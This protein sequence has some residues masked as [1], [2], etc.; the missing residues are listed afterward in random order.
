[1]TNSPLYKAGTTIKP[2]GAFIHSVGCPQP[3]ASAFIKTMN[4]AT[5]TK[6]VTA[7]IQPDGTVYETLPINFSKKT[8]IKNWHAGK[9]SKG[10]ANTSW[11]GIELTEPSTI[12]YTSGASFKDLDPEKTKE[13]VANT[14]KYAVEYF[15]YLCEGFGWDPL[16]DGVILSHHEGYVRGYASNHGDVEHIWSKYGYTMDQFRK[17]VKEEMDKDKKKTTT[18]SS[19]TTKK[20]ASSSN[21]NN[22]KAVTKHLQVIAT[23]GLNIREG[24]GTNTKKVGAYAFGKCFTISKVSANGNW[25]YVSGKGWLNISSKYVKT[26]SRVEITCSSLNVRAKASILGKKVCTVSKGSKHYVTRTSGKWGWLATKGW[27]NISSKYAKKI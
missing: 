25:G 20:V 3:K 14:Y 18:T 2:K 13:H 15:A 8:A 21:T 26:I 17:D 4:K 1:M 9:G 22:T 7:F 27:A 6:G 19:S 24:A 12:K 23:D 11:I 16:E 5:A 10:S